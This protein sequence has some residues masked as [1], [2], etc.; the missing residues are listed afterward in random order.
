MKLLEHKNIIITGARRGI[1]RAAVELFAEY[2]ANLWA[3]ARTYDEVFERDMRTIALK[4]KVWIK[5]IYFDMTNSTEIKKAVDD[6]RKEKKEIDALVNNAGVSYDALLPMISMEKSYNLFETN[7]FACVRLTQLVGRIMIKAKKG[8]IVNTASYL[9][10]DGNKGQTMYSASK[11]AVG[12]MTKSL[13]KELAE[14]NI[15]VNAIAPG[16]VDTEMISN[17]PGREFEKIMDRC[18]MHRPAKPKEIAN[19][20]AVLASDLS[21]YITGQIIRVDG[22]LG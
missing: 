11:A 12:A 9:G 3:C 2:G 20:I 22:G 14:Y 15:R 7:Y 21:S 16:V 6:I 18:P 4:N 10:C 17:M 13:A 1:G 8:C 5:P 19:I